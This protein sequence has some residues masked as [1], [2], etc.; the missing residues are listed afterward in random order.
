MDVGSAVQRNKADSERVN[1]VSIES[2]IKSDLASKIST[3]KM[4]KP[5]RTTQR[6]GRLGGVKREG[7]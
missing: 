3:S 4:Q 5:A 1:P 7:A 2:D 6:T